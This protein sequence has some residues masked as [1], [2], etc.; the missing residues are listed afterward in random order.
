MDVKLKKDE[1]DWGDYDF[2]SEVKVDRY[3]VEV[4][5]AENPS[6]F[7]KYA[8][9]Y[10]EAILESDR[11][12]E[13][14]KLRKEDLSDIVARLDA[15]IRA[16]WQDMKDKEGNQLFQKTPSEASIS[17]WIILQPEY[18]ESQGA[19]R[20]AREES[21]EWNYVKERFG[22]GVKAFDNRKGTLDKLGDLLCKGIY[23][24]VKRGTSGREMDE[25]AGGVRE[26][27]QSD[28]IGRT[29]GDR[30][31]TPKKEKSN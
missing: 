5:L 22:L 25:R 17:N 7:A 21:I 8:E 2:R 6:L 18:K 24:Y 31:P 13:R 12:D 23:S 4:Q 29:M 28:R 9:P 15:R 26:V 20:D 27:G 16:E 10:A 3:Q 19:L 11:A 14:I 1:I 30:K